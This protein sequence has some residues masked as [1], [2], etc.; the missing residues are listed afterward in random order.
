MAE[1]NGTVPVESFED[2][3]RTHLI[4]NRQSL[5]K[6]AVSG[7]MERMAESMKWTAME[8]ANKQLNEFFKAEVGP[9]IGKY[10]TENR[11]ALIAAVI[12]TIKTVLDAGLKAQAEE[13]TKEMASSYSRARTIA[14]MFGSK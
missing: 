14:A 3:I 2:V 7:A 1:E 13:W 9:E 12:G 10:L 11:E 5:V 8:H 4:E 6:Q